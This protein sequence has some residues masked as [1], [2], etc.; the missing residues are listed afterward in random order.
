MAGGGI[1]VPT[2]AYCTLEDVQELLPNRVYNATSRP[3]ISQAIGL[4][5]AVAAEI[6]AILRGLEYATVPFTD[7]TDVVLLKEINKVGAAYRI[8]SSTNASAQSDSPALDRLERMYGSMIENL[9][10]GA[11]KFA[12]AGTPPS[13]EPD[14]NDDLDASGTRSEPIFSISQDA[15]D[16]KY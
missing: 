13:A 4:V 10:K 3:T 12:S 14:G 11:Y 15:R 7:A 9:R 6:N 5:K 16:R 1:I 8:E 2:E